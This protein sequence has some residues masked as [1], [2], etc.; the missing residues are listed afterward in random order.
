MND[1]GMAV[2]AMIVVR[3]L[4]RKKY[5]ITATTTPATISLPC[6]V[7]TDDSM[8]LAWRMVICGSPMPAG[9]PFF[10]SASA[11]SIFF[12]SATVSASGCF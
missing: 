5:R 2:S 4:S 8:K 3:R 6:S 12:V 1:S 10:I 11:L 9:K 7:L